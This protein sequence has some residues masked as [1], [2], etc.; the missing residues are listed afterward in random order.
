MRSPRLKDEKLVKMVNTYLRGREE[1]T[2][3]EKK[4]LKNK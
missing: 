4:V 1:S 3:S 2:R